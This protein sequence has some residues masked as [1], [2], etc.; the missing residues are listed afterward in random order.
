MGYLDTLD[1]LTDEAVRKAMVYGSAVA[2]F[3]VE[4]LGPSRLLTLTRAEVETR[5]RAFRRLTHFEVPD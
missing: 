2:S 3:A 1:E 5:F 4:G